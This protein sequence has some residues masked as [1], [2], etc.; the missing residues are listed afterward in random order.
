MG[1]IAGRTTRG[2]NVSR[3]AKELR[4]TAERGRLNHGQ[5]LTSASAGGADHRSFRPRQLLIAAALTAVAAAA[6][7]GCGGSSGGGSG[8]GSAKATDN[9]YAGT[10]TYWYW[11]ESDAPGANNWMKSM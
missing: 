1:P 4:A 2:R 7:A 9:P 3:I 8:G 10:M 11:G 5:R 6:L